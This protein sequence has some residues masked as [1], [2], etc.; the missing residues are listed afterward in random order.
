MVITG[1]EAFI[2]ENLDAPILLMPSEIKS[3]GRKVQN[4]AMIT[5]IIN[6]F[7]DNAAIVFSGL[8][9]EKKWILIKIK[10]KVT[11]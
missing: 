9:T 6:A 7:P 11:A 10:E 1:P 2:K 3:N 5:M 4:I 8:K